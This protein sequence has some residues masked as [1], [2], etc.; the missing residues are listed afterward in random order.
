MPVPHNQDLDA[1][2][3]ASPAAGPGSSGAPGR[4]PGVVLAH[5]GSSAWPGRFAVAAVHFGW[6]LAKAAQRPG[7]VVMLRVLG[8]G[9]AQVALVGDEQPAGDLAA[10]EADVG[11]EVVG[12]LGGRE[13]PATVPGVTI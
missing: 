4:N 6:A 9:L 10:Q 1:S 13:P 7:G 11:Q 8:Q 12:A 3:M 2:S 5:G